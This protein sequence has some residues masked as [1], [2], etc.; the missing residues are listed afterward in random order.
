MIDVNDGVYLGRTLD[1]SLC[2]KLNMLHM[3]HRI[4]HIY[5][6]DHLALSLSLSLTHTLLECKISIIDR[7]YV[8][9]GLIHFTSVPA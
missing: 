2:D 7:S 8:W 6:A 1:L 3:L 4:G 5:M 9:F